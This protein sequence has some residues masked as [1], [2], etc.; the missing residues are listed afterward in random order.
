MPPQAPG[1]VPMS[2]VRTDNENDAY[3]NKAEMSVPT[4]Q[5]AKN[6]SE[7]RKKRRKRE[8]KLGNH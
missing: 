4:P 8:E 5:R 6:P 7:A 2:R 1:G 3:A